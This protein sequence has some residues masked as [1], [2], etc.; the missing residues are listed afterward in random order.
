MTTQEST[1][2]TFIFLALAICAVWLK[3]V[4]I[5]KRIAMPP[6]IAFFAASMVS[7]LVAG[8]LNPLSIGELGIFCGAAYLARA[9]KQKSMQ[10]FFFS[11]LTVILA[12]ALA[13]HRLPGF[14]NPV[15]IS[16]MTLSAGAAA[17]TQYANFDKGAVG[18]ILLAFLCNRT[19]A[20]SE[21]G[22]LLKQTYPIT[23][24]TV[25]AI[26]GIAMSIGYIE[27]DFK[28][29]QTT[30][31]FL[32]IN[33]F[34]TVIAEET[35]F[36]GFLQ[37]RLALSL[38]RFRYGRLSA[39]MCSALLFGAAH[40]AGGTTYVLL[41]SLAGLGYTYAYFITQRIE[42]PVLVHFSLNAVHFIGFTYPYL[43]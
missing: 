7:G 38:A 5:G 4:Y 22:K 40:L 28:I 29:T 36:R 19:S 21:S 9:S 24:I 37:D 23:L 10:R 31:L 34:F 13:L 41:A 8:V 3:P 33:L 6:W 20:F 2:I 1:L 18:L 11:T 25:V 42:A 16:S 15:V 26:L 12:L 17:F 35:F 39:A 27:H 14:N 30:M 32:V 43:S